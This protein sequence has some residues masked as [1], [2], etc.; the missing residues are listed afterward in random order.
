MNNQQTSDQAAVLINELAFCD[1]SLLLRSYVI[2]IIQNDKQMTVKLTSSC[3]FLV[4][5]V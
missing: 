2:K 4:E 5:D 3:Q 1:C